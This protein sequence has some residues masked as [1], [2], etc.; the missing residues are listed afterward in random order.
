[1]T[2]AL[3]ALSVVIVSR[4]RP[5][6]L[7]RAI[8]G[9]CQQ[10]HPQI[11]L[12]VVADPAAAA[13]VTAAHPGAHA[14]AFDRPNISAARNLGLDLAAAPVVAFLDDDAVPEPDWARR[15]ATVFADPA[16]TQAGGFVRGPDGV[17]FQWQGVEVDHLGADHPLTVQGTTIRPGSAARAIKTQGTNCAFRAAALRAAGGFDPA[18]AF[19][20]DEADV[21]L[22]LAAAGGLTAVV[23]G[24]VVHHGYAAS[25]R[26]RA[27]RAPLTLFDIGASMAVF[28]R[29]HA[30]PDAAPAALD[31]LRADQRARLVRMMVA[32][33]IEP[34]DVG[35]LMATLQQGIAEGQGRRLPDLAPRPGCR[36]DLHPLPGTGPRPVQVFRGR[37]S[38][39]RAAE[40]RAR[41]AIV[42]VER[43]G[44]PWRR[45]RVRFGDDGLWQATA[46]RWRDLPE[47]PPARRCGTIPPESAV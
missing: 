35:R 26:R 43:R 6:A 39:A 28:L 23:P 19:Y 42:T 2:G 9:V 15:L 36:R 5:A 16:V 31:R 45:P 29:R 46:G 33:L 41:G 3:P 17:R 7:M 21:N 4:H 32:G 18:F 22:R 20:L 1:M 25:P 8:A 12:I 44:P 24:A 14:L 40:A 13:Q 27:D 30:P 37:G 10:D 38:L 34:R 11:E 47:L